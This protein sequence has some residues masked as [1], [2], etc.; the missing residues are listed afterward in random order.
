MKGFCCVISAKWVLFW[1]TLQGK[2]SEDHENPLNCVRSQANRPIKKDNT[3]DRFLSQ[4]KKGSSNAIP[5]AAT[6]LPKPAP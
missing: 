1:N 2:P 5:E 4:K 6:V 3:T